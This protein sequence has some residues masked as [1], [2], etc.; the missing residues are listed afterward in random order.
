MRFLEPG[1]AAKEKERQEIAQAELFILAQHNLAPEEELQD[2]GVKP[3]TY[4]QVAEKFGI[5]KKYIDNPRTIILKYR[6]FECPMSSTCSS[7][8]WI[9]DDKCTYECRKE[10]TEATATAEKYDALIHKVD[11]LIDNSESFITG[12]PEDSKIW[13]DD[14]EKLNEI[15]ELLMS[16]KIHNLKV[17]TK[18]ES[19]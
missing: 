3:L 4:N 5:V 8:G 7:L 18:N 10:M 17:E 1:A 14:V 19:T 15:K 11:D 12:D 9:R 6:D 2:Q 13:T 16:M